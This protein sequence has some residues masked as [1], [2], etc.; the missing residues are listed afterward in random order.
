MIAITMMSALTFRGRIMGAS[1]HRIGLSAIANL[2]SSA[3][4]ALVLEI[5]VRM[6]AMNRLNLFRVIVVTM[7][8]NGGVSL[9]GSPSVWAASPI[10]MP[11]SAYAVPTKRVRLAIGGMDCKNCES[12]IKG[13]LD[14][15][16]GIVS[17][18]V[19]YERQEAVVDYDPAKINPAGIIAA[20]KGAGFTAKVKRN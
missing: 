16:P 15:T 18:S 10:G 11:S 1:Y 19:S 13:E 3:A 4:D 5:V 2:S 8:I 14:R 20:I 7:L 6:F 12:G 9:P 17:S